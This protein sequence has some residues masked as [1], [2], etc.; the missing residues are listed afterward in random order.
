MFSKLLS[1]KE[2]RVTEA[3]QLH[4]DITIDLLRLLESE[5]HLDASE[6]LHDGLDA[7]FYQDI[8]RKLKANEKS[9]SILLPA[10]RQP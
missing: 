1:N 4:F 5:S 10:E 6:G 7:L 8:F 9:K 3:E 2:R